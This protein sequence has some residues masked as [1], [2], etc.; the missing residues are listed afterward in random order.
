MD[1]LYHIFFV[2]QISV[3]TEIV[4]QTVSEYTI[5]IFNVF[6]AGVF[7]CIPFLWGFWRGD[8]HIIH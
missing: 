6:W 2:K 3:H 7:L 1:S 4:E 8:E 5:A